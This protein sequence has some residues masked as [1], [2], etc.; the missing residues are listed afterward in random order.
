VIQTG[1]DQQT[2]RTIA[3]SITTVPR[4]FNLKSQD[5]WLARTTRE[6]G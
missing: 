6:D 1:V 3:H 4:G 2:L 5:R